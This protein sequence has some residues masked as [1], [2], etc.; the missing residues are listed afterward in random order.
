[1]PQMI[2]V[3]LP[4]TDLEKSKSFYTAIG[5]VINPQFS[6]DTAACVVISDSIFLMILT[7][8][9]FDSFL[10]NPRA[11]TATTTSAL[12]ALTRDSRAD[13]DAITTAALMAGGA[14]PKP[15]SDHGFM[16]TRTFHDP[17]GNVFEPFWMDPG[18][19][20]S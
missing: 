17:D 18:F 19:V 15:A 3:N 2:F 16:Y 13:V 12:I 6:D 9:K 7:H 14:E 1:M 11:D 20:Q 10:T 5:F 8:A 4:V